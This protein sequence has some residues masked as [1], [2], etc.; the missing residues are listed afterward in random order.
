MGDTE[1]GERERYLSGSRGALVGLADGRQSAS[2]IV[3]GVGQHGGSHRDNPRAGS[4][5]DG[6]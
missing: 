4:G 1:R 3:G 2:L 6:G 5:E